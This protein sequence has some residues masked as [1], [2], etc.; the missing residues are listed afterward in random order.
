MTEPQNPS[1]EEH[2]QR[3]LASIP[4]EPWQGRRFQP[5]SYA[6][7]GPALFTTPDNVTHL[8]V[9]GH[10]AVANWLEAEG[11]DDAADQ[12]H[13]VLDGLPYVRV[14]NGTQPLTTSRTDSHR[15]ASAYVLNGK[16]ADGVE[17]RKQLVAEC[18]LAPKRP[19]DWELMARF[20]FRYDPLSLLHGVF[21]SLGDIHGNPRFPRIVSGFVEADE[22]Q[23][24]SKGGARV[25]RV[26]SSKG[27]GRTA[28]G[29][30][31]NVPLPITDDYTAER[32]TLYWSLD[33]TALTATRLPDAAQRLLEYVGQ[34]QLRRLVDAPIKPRSFCDLKANPPEGLPAA[35]ELER[36]I[37]EGIAACSAQGLFADPLVTVV[38]HG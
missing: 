38:T 19:I 20:C 36:L 35:V 1:Y 4:L 18:G 24:A 11:W 26:D 15:L 2:P 34:W 12:P 25:D 6:N 13:P 5:A 31:G 10:A 33:R 9:D 28:E 21:F 29:G 23:P 14:T 17:F 27:E 22:V 37:S 7:L 30:Y 3:V 16:T 8:Q 32:I